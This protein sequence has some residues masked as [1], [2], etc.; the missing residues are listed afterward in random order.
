MGESG[1][2][3]LVFFQAKP[4]KIA[5][6]SRRMAGFV[7]H[8]RYNQ[9]REERQR[10]DNSNSPA[11]AK[12]VSETPDKQSADRVSAITPEA[13]DADRRGSPSWV[14]YIADGG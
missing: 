7:H 13:V 4:D 8:C 5:N 11:Y 14:R 6:P 2:H 3:V 9:P 10:S 1:F 12:Y